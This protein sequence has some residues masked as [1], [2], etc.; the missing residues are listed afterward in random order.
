MAFEYIKKDTPLDRMNPLVKMAYVGIALIYAL[1]MNNVTQFA[2][3]IVWILIAMLWWI[4]GKVELR[5]LGILLSLLKYMVLFLMLLQGLTYRFGDQTVLFQFFDWPSADGTTNYGALTAGGVLF[6]L[7]VSTRIVAVLAVIPIFTMTTSMSRLNAALAKVRVPQ[8]MIFMFITAMRFVPLVQDS[9]N[10][11]I[12]AQKIRGFD[13]DKA[14]FYQKIRRAY[15][16]IITPLILLMFRRAMDLEVAINARAF[17][18]KKERTYIEDISFKRVDYF[19]FLAVGII[20]VFIMYLQF[21]QAQLLWDYLVLIVVFIA[22]WVVNIVTTLGIDVLLQ[23]FNTFL[24]G[25]PYLTIFLSY[26]DQHV[27]TGYGGI[28]GLIIALFVV[29]KLIRRYV[30]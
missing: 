9:W 25:V 12:D 8:K 6:G 28:V 11:I 21:Y 17:G 30:G 13:I 26:F 19:G 5:S 14:N 27:L 1:T 23:G 20:F 15:I 24:L 10:A 29:Y 2:V 22:N 16:P 7:F 4:V 18:A 3:V